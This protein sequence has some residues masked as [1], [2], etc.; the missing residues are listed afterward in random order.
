MSI[1]MTGIDHNLAGIDV[2]TV[3]SFTKKKMEEALGYLKEVPGIDGC[4]ILSTC[5]RMEL[6]ASTS[7]EFKGS[8]IELLGKI[9]NVSMTPYEGYFISREGYEAVHHL[10]RLAGGLESRILGEDQIVTQVGDAL[11][12]AREQYAADH[13]ME[14]L[15]R[16]A[17]TAA[18]KVKTDIELSPADHS[19]VRT[20]INTLKQD[21]MEF[22]GKKCLVI[23]NGVMGKLAA[24][25]LEKEGADV[26]VTVRQY[27]SGVVEIPHGC[28]R[29]DYGAR[30]SLF[31][32]CD[33][34]FS[35]TV[36]PNFTLT[37]ELV[38]QG[39]THPMVL[40]DLAVPRDFDPAIREIPGVSLYD[41]DCFREEARSESQK[42]AIAEAEECFAVQIGEFYS[43]YEGRDLIP[44]IQK[45][46]EEAAVDLEVRLTK[47]L[48]QLPVGESDRE[49]LK[50][51]ILQASM[52]AVNKMLFGLRDEI[53]R[54]AF[55]ECLDG[56]EKVYEEG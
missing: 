5:N 41:I 45:I 29:I 35:A 9:K 34:V 24:T 37:K 51:D 39:M 50:E 47:K 48:Q 32:A 10:F 43:W 17:V 52:R 53:S 19:V 30:M 8:L 44:R 40:V 42:A 23:G 15:F 7:E 56:L 55:L 22:A 18:K 21:G 1:Q 26:T 6:W 25:T 2:R 38:E 46:K 49:G 36:S 3:F 14:T 27:R 20:A 13:V 16:M 28:K 12:F 11:S 31:G 33:Y 4:V 54:K